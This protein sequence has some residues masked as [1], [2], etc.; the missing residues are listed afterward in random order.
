MIEPDDKMQDIDD[1]VQ[2]HEL[3]EEQAV[4]TAE[5]VKTDETT[6]EKNTPQKKKKKTAK[7]YAIRF[8]IRIGIAALVISLTL[9]FVLGVYVNHSNSSYPMIKD[10]DL[11]F[12]FKLAKL[13]QGDVTAF[14]SGDE[15]KFGRVVAIEGDTVEIKNGQVLVNGIG[16]YEDTVYSTSS[17]GSKIDYPYNV[18]KDTVF[19]LNDLRSDTSDSRTLGGIPLSDCKGKVIFVMRR[20]GI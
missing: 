8:F 6:I 7:Q 17:E 3:A 10:G 9:V 2:T 4:E 1:P 16:L 11:C 20:R 19:V 13:K 15:I 14:R 18:P 12:S 5:D